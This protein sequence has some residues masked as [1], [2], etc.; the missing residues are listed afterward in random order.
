MYSSYILV[1]VTRFYFFFVLEVVFKEPWGEEYMS[2][3]SFRVV[4]PS[5]KSHNN[6]FI[7]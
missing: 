5:E 3:D 6:G 7:L 1:N 2:W 4:T